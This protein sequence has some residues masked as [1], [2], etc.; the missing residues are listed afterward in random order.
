MPLPYKDAIGTYRR[1]YER[2]NLFLA[3]L[4]FRAHVQGDFFAG[5]KRTVQFVGIS[6]LYSHVFHWV[7]IS[8]TGIKVKTQFEHLTYKSVYNSF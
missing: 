8:Q 4:L 2:M 3:A 1:L 7:D 5:L 6:A